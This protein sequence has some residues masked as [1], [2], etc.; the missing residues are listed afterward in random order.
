M[1]IA[2]QHFC[3]T[4]DDVGGLALAVFFPS[5]AC[6]VCLQY[7]LAASEKLPARCL[8]V[9]SDECSRNAAQSISIAI[10]TSYLFQ[11]FS[12]T[13]NTHWEWE[14]VLESSL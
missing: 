4:R 9:S 10:S 6:Y 2:V 13:S 14:I 1:L 3:Q 11:F 8:S 7:Q 5:G 12:K